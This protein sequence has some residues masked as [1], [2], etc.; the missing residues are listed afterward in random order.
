MNT[1]L[2]QLKLPRVNLCL[3]TSTYVFQVTI[4]LH[5][6][7]NVLW[8]QLK[9][10][11]EIKS[12]FR[13]CNIRLYVFYYAFFWLWSGVHS[14]KLMAVGHI[15]YG[16][17]IILQLKSNWRK[18]VTKQHLTSISFFSVFRWLFIDS[19]C[20]HSCSYTSLTNTHVFCE[21]IRC[22]LNS[23]MCVCVPMPMYTVCVL[24][25]FSVREWSPPCRDSELQLLFTPSPIP[26]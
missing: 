1:S 14:Q 8:I 17:Q 12:P 13:F 7:K 18:A 24:L 9:S 4:S 21:C 20:S 19:G 10:K 11:K 5:C 23:W 15:A 2:S 3:F 22:I 16:L 6:L 25:S 26:Q